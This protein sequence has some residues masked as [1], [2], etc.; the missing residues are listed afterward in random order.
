M[1]I[2][3]TLAQFEGSKNQGR[4]LFFLFS[5][6]RK[7]KLSEEKLPAAHVLFESL[8]VCMNLLLLFFQV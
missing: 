5:S 2:N 7:M 3:F 4:D 6:W 1:N 8:F